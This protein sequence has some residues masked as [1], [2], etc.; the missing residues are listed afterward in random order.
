MGSVDA[1]NDVVAE[2]DDVVVRDTDAD[3]DTDREDDGEL[4]NTDPAPTATKD[5]FADCDHVAVVGSVSP[6]V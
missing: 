4:E 1:D 2:L 5:I 6:I 3:G